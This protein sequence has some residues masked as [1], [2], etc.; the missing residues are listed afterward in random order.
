MLLEAPPP[1]RQV[2]S[3]PVSLNDASAVLEKYLQNSETHAHLHP[4]AL[5]TPD[6]V[7]FNAKGGAVGNLLMHHLRRV[8]AGLR[9]E[10]LEP[11]TTLEAQDEALDAAADGEG[12]KNTGA[13]QEWQD[14]ATYQAEQGG[15]E[16]GDVG[17]RTNV[18]QEGEQEPPVQINGTKKRKQDQA[19]DHSQQSP[20]DGQ[21][22]KD[23]RKKAKKE[24]DL[25][26]KR[27][28]AAKAKKSD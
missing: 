16:I 28:N 13:D 8:A 21:V 4:D 15:I 19:H 7:T 5:I 25:Q 18:V 20:P 24:R 9:G 23:A 3:V 2:S 22:D 10:Y 26:R 17:N 12:S 1:R 14:A 6:G 11:D 27:D